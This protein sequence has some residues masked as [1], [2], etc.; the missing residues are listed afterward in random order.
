MK[1]FYF[2]LLV[3][4]IAIVPQWTLAQGNGSLSEGEI[5]LVENKM[6]PFHLIDK[7]TR[8]T[9][10]DATQGYNQYLQSGT[11]GISMSQI[12]G[13]IRKVISFYIKNT[14]NDSIYITK[15]SIRNSETLDVVNTS[16]DTSLLGT[17]VP[18]Q[19]K[20]LSITLRS[21]ISLVYEW[22]YVYKGETYTFRSWNYDVVKVS[23]ITLNHTELTIK[24][25]EYATLTATV[26]PEDARIK[27][28]KWSSSNKNVVSIDG[29]GIMI[30]ISEGTADVICS[31]TDGSGVTATCKVTVVKADETEVTDYNAYLQSSTTGYSKIQFGS[32]VSKSIN[33]NIKNN[34]SESIYLTK[35]TAKNAATMENVGSSTD[36]DLLGTLEAGATKSLSM[37]VHSDIDLVY[38]WEYIYKGKSFVFQSWETYTGIQ[39]IKSNVENR[40]DSIYNLNGMK[41]EKEPDHGIFI[42]NGKK[43]IVR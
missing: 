41:L 12:G 4:F 13:T 36:T 38:E 16:T 6:E 27:D 21:D 15:L 42:K 35:L 40:E 23:S 26:S 39:T 29:N 17:L 28:V 1:K 37:T 2:L 43:V 5:K 25:G 32:T 7:T 10:Y 20:G 11:S 19:N 9:G 8:A 33:F 3:L 22:E 30:G 14:G 34:G 24:A 31:A 18:D